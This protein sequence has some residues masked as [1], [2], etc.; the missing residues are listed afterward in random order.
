MQD[1][2]A[3]VLCKIA[4]V[5]RCQCQPVD[6]TFYLSILACVCCFLN[7]T[8]T[9]TIFAYLRFLKI[10]LTTTSSQI[11]APYFRI[12]FFIVT[13]SLIS[14]LNRALNFMSHFDFCISLHCHV[15]DL[16]DAKIIVKGL[17][18]KVKMGHMIQM[19]TAAVR[20]R[21]VWISLRN[22]SRLICIEFFPYHKTKCFVSHFVSSPR[23][24]TNV[25]WIC[26]Q[27]CVYL[28]G[29][30]LW[31]SSSDNEFVRVFDPWFWTC[32]G[33][34][35]LLC[36]SNACLRT[37]PTDVRNCWVSNGA[38]WRTM[39]QRSVSSLGTIIVWRGVR[40]TNRSVV[41][42]SAS[43]TAAAAAGDRPNYLGSAALKWVVS[44]AGHFA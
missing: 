5:C 41:D 12:G 10:G 37:K 20:W 18:L 22:L 3:A 2:Y 14:D 7:S 25:N 11:E 44:A 31:N 16:E 19:P 34:P 35:V 40:I 23:R 27:L 8:N 42:P 24:L 4:S 43:A 28:R 36:A 30:R 32:V 13:S 1:T 6:S 38:C 39:L 9:T 21:H 26:E 29:K 33:F 15:C 17:K